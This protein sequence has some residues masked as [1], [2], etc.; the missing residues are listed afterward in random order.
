MV[1]KLQFRL[2]PTRVT[3]AMFTTAIRVTMRQCSIAIAPDGS[4]TKGECKLLMLL[5]AL[6]RIDQIVKHGRFK[7]VQTVRLN[8]ASITKYYLWENLIEQY[9]CELLFK[10]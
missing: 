8:Y 6:M 10:Q 4:W 5:R 1:L 7:S 2:P 9:R 3:A